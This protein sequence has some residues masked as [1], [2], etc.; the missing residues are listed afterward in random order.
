[1]FV[2]TSLLTL[3]TAKKSRK[4]S[5]LIYKQFIPVSGFCKVLFVFGG[6]EISWSV[7]LQLLSFPLRCSLLAFPARVVLCRS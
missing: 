3:I 4:Q 5:K 1:M 6:A 2:L 7:L